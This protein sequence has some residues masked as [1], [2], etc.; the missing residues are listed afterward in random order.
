MKGERGH[1]QRWAPVCPRLRRVQEVA[2][3]K[4][5]EQFTSLAHLVTEASLLRSYRG[6]KGTASPG[7]DG[8][9]KASY[10]RHLKGNLKQLHERVR[11]DQYRACP[12]LRRWLDKPDGG[13]RAIG[14]P[15][16]EDKIVQG[17]VVEILNSIYEEDFHGFSYGFRPGRNPHQ[18]LRALQTVLQ[19]GRVNWVLELDLEACFDRIGHA[20]LREV[21]RRR[22][23]DRRLLKLIGKWLKVGTVEV[24]GRRERSRVGI[25]QGAVISPLLANIVLHYAMDE[26]VS[27]WRRQYATGEVY[28]VRYADDAVLC[29]EH[30]RDAHALR[31]ELEASL[32]DYGLSL[33]EGK[34]R[35]LRFGRAWPK[36]GHRSESFDFLGFTHLAGRDRQGRYL[37]IRKT[38]AKRLRRSLKAIGQWCKGHRHAPL[39]WQCAELS[40]KLRGH[41]GYYGIRGNYAALARFRHR[42]RQL[43]YQALRRRSQR[44]NRSRLARLLTERFVLPQPHL[45]HPDNWLAVTP[46]YLLGRAGCGN[47]ARPVL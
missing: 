35:L 40:R 12:V 43:W 45:T 13:K 27:D 2:R 46:G 42:A 33:N 22:V 17:A 3:A 37:V 19:K 25:P 1:T 7:V 24:D 18:A 20:A 38:Q 23:I 9:T 30:E 28:V 31:A 32:A 47:A 41:Y 4:P 8:E 21:L 44:V 39:A 6:L 16:L 10:G 29:F 11:A 5:E 36:R 26:V 15:A 14:L 34:T